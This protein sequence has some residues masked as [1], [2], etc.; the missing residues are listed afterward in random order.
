MLLGVGR[1]NKC[2]AGLPLWPAHF[3]CLVWSAAWPAVFRQ[4]RYCEGSKSGV[5]L[6]YAAIACTHALTRHHLLP[7]VPHWASGRASTCR[8]PQRVCKHTF[9]GVLS[10][11]FSR[12]LDCVQGLNNQAPSFALSPCSGLISVHASSA[13]SVLAGRRRRA[14]FH[15]R[16]RQALS[17]ECCLAQ[18]LLC[19]VV[20]VLMLHAAKH[21]TCQGPAVPCMR[22]VP[23]ACDLNLFLLPDCFLACFSS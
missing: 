21:A 2:T 17:T 16:I 15:W 3:L 11:C 10:S 18:G 12:L 13:I 19:T 9:I 20:S 23:T 8:S 1:G 4:C 6:P 22:Q 5:E 7:A 14:A